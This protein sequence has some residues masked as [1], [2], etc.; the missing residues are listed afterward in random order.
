[1]EGRY[2]LSGIDGLYLSGQTLIATQN[3]T[4]PQRVI[5]FKFNLE[6]SH[7]ES[8]SLIERAS[9]TLG[10]PTHGV[11]VDG[12]FYYIA[13]SGWNT[14]DEH[15]NLKPGASMSAAHVMKVAIPLK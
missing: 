15:G 4:S 1:M 5:Q 7:V 3:G 2:A 10:D 12:H 13:N 8:E 9:P 11:I 14:M 6:F